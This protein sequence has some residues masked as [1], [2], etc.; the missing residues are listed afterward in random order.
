MLI[1][2]H[3]EVLIRN[4]FSTQNKRQLV[5][6]VVLARFTFSHDTTMP[7][8]VW[9]RLLSLSVHL[10]VTLHWLENIGLHGFW[11]QHYYASVIVYLSCHLGKSGP[12]ARTLVCKGQRNEV[13]SV[14]TQRRITKEEA[15]H[16][17]NKMS[18]QFERILEMES[19]VKTKTFR[20]KVIDAHEGKKNSLIFSSAGWFM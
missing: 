15:S 5:C 17:G 14:I 11:W 1:D 19:E 2:T 9:E 12:A 3:S 13:L 16:E 20:D 4:W 6:P 7:M 10:S 18:P 8:C